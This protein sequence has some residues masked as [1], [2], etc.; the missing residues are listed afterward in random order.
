MTTPTHFDTL[1]KLS[2]E[3]CVGNMNNT[4]YE[5]LLA[6]INNQQAHITAIH[7]TLHA[8]NRTSR[9]QSTALLVL[10]IAM[11]VMSFSKYFYG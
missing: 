9:M 3:Q 7:E 2:M 10:A 5:R 4:E 11:A 6:R 8:L 1:L